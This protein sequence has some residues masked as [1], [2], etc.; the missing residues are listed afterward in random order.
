MKV[1][2]VGAS[3]VNGYATKNYFKNI[4]DYE[5]LTLSRGTLYDEYDIN[6][7]LEIDLLSPN[8]YEK[9]SEKLKDVTHIFYAALKPN[10]NAKVEADENETMLENCVKIV[11]EYSD[12]LKHITFLQGGKVYGAHL[13]TYKTPAIENQTKHFPPNLYFRHEMFCK[14]LFKKSKITYTALRPDI[15]IGYS[16]YSAMNLGNLIGVYATIC[17]ETGID[18]AFPG[19]RKT[20]SK[21]ANVTDADIVAN[22]VK[23][24]FDDETAINE[25][26]NITNGDI[27][28]WDYLWNKIAEF[29]NMKVGESQPITLEKYFDYNE[30]FWKQ[31]VKKYQLRNLKISDIVKGDFG[32]FIFNVNNDAI[33]DVN[34]ARRSGFKM[35]N[36]DTSNSIIDHLKKLQDLSIIPKF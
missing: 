19:N 36:R 4:K 23:W 10:T 2:I 32:D 16:L 33:F 17:K 3:G 28:R 34:K 26:F 5:Y 29:Y 7:H 35:M 30:G 25:S 15:V 12:K 24:S 8:D 21:L 6:K 14:T 11:R 31:L 1:L 20:Y 9:Y 27:F 13:G 22:A 18:L